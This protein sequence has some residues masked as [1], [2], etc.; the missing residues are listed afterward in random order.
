[1]LRAVNAIN[2]PLVLLSALLAMA[3]SGTCTC[4]EDYVLGPGDVVR[5]TVYAQPDLSTVT[6]VNESGKSTLPLIGEVAVGGL[7]VSA[8]ETRIADLLRQGG[9]VNTPQ[10]TLIIE[11]Y[12]SQ[13]VSVLGQV[14]KPGKYAIEGA[15][16]IVD[17]LAMAGGITEN[18]ADTIK[19]IKASDATRQQLRVDLVALLQ[20]GDMKQNIEITGGDIVYVPKMDVFYIYGEVQRP[21]AFRLERGMTLVQALAVG[22]GLTSR[23]TERGISV[24]RQGEHSAFETVAGQLTDTL[25]PNDVIY[26][27]ES[28]F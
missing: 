14:H 12:R 10:V 22:G 28:L 25:R 16:T 27:K 6:R 7:T 20:Q 11:Q 26:V 21:G 2:R 15:S 13:Q 8:A 23:G 1:M 4:A 3:W 19:I 5:M 24:K 17:M 9:Y 18:G